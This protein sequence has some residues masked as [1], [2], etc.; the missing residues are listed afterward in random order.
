MVK[1]LWLFA[2]LAALT[3][4]KDK[5]AKSGKGQGD[6]TACFEV[7]NGKETSGFPEVGFIFNVGSAVCSGTFVGHN[8][9]FTA[10]H[11]LD[12]KEPKKVAYLNT[13]TVDV[14][15]IETYSV[16][17]AIDVLWAGDLGLG[18]EPPQKGTAG[19]LLDF[20][21]IIFPDHTAPAIAAIYDGTP[22]DGSRGVLVGYGKVNGAGTPQSELEG[23]TQQVIKK[24]VGVNK[25]VLAE[26]FEDAPYTGA[27]TI[28]GQAINGEPNHPDLGSLVG[29]G[30]SGGPMFI[31]GKI[32]GVA[33][34]GAYA[35]EIGQPGVNGVSV[36]ASLDSAPNKKLIAEAKA[37]GAKIGE[38]NL[39]KSICN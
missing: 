38:G 17:A 6:A 33:S 26:P 5:G 14:E 30:D 20:A 1:K 32:A 39:S 8:V 27:L 7:V 16:A 3:S 36:Y 21:I 13:S 10:A 25:H 24:R 35:P 23:K 12:A 22:P 15:K 29:Q 34:W 2:G 18:D 11:C 28:V 37:K 4:C 31:D 19:E 9:M